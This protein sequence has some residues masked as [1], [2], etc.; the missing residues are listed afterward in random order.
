MDEKAELQPN[1][2][3]NYPPSSASTV[4]SDN[5]PK[6][7]HQDTYGESE[8][9]QVCIAGLKI[10]FDRASLFDLFNFVCLF[11]MQKANTKIFVVN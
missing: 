11:Q 6:F 7:G 3:S 10:S 1:H 8:A 5:K 9:N 4:A 2:L